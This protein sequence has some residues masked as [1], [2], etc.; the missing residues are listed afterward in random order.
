M[1]LENRTRSAKSV[2]GV[3]VHDGR[4]YLSV[5]TTVVSV[6]VDDPTESAQRTYTG[7]PSADA[8]ITA[9]CPA[10]DGLYAGNADGQIIRWSYDGGTPT[11]IH[12]GSG[13]A[14]ES[15]HL[16]TAGGLTRLFFSD[17]T[18]ALHARVIGDSF[19]CRYEAGGQTLRRVEV[20]P[21]L[22]I[23]TNEVRDRLI[24]WSPGNPTAPTG[25]ISVARQTG[26]TVQDVCLL[27]MG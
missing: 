8:L 19:T 6:E 2:R 7:P 20:A 27:P 5:D 3:Q 13:R 12:S 4:I 22:L 25:T 11:I 23:A 14:A 17:T 21:D 16:L 18:L 15:I 24:H 9:L 1:L 10:P 26:H